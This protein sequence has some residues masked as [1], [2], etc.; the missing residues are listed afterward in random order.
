MSMARNESTHQTGRMRSVMTITA[1][2][3]HGG[4]ISPSSRL[5]V[6]YGLSKMFAITPRWGYVIEDVKIDGASVG[7][8]STYLFTN[9][10]DDHTI[11]VTFWK[12]A[13]NIDQ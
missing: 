4:V 8:V 6:G 9:L 7:P 3:G 2:S 13:K 11:G 5:S 10:I 12:S 1:T